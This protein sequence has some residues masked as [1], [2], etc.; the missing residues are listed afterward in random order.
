M[1]KSEDQIAYE[2]LLPSLHESVAAGHIGHYAIH[3]ETRTVKVWPVQ[4]KELTGVVTITIDGVTKR[5][6]EWASQFRDG[7]ASQEF[8]NELKKYIGPE[9]K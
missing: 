1:N 9:A 4:G 7:L 5:A 2:R 3:R 6:S 8:R